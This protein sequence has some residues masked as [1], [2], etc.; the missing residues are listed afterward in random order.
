M[1]APHC[2]GRCIRREPLEMLLEEEEEEEEEGQIKYSVE[3][4]GAGNFTA[5]LTV[6]V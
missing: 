5:R 1:R 6:V 2:L 4:E 3:L